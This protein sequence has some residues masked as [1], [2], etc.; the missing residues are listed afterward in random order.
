MT[1]E[2]LQVKRCGLGR[3]NR[4]LVLHMA[5]AS[6]HQSHFQDLVYHG[7]GLRVDGRERIR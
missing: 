2:D 3:P 1:R 7:G 6:P 5:L 4:C